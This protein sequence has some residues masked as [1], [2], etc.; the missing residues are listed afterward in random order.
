MPHH[1]PV[2]LHEAVAAFGE[3]SG[4]YVA[5]G[6]LGGGGHTRALLAAGASV[7][8]TDWDAA[9]VAAAQV[10]VSEFAGRLEL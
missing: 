8:A 7:V 4:Q 9:A 6:T 5:D 2:M 1:I 10:W 3:I